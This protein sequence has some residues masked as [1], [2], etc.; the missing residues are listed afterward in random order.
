MKKFFL[1]LTCSLLFAVSGNAQLFKKGEN[2][3][4]EPK[5][6][7]GAV[8]VVNGKV[9]FEKTIEANELTADVMKA[10]VLEWA[11][12]RF[13]TPTVIKGEVGSDMDVVRIAVEEYMV[14]QNKFLVLD[15]TRIY[16]SLEITCAD[17]KCTLRMGNI[18]YW[19]E[20]ERDGG[21]RFTAEERITDEQAMNKKHTKFYRD[22]G[23]FRTK[24]IDLADELAAQIT[25][26]LAH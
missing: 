4:I 18:K 16:Y 17:G 10:K 11:A 1:L 23:K 7:A 12:T 9:L 5:Y 14:F 15:R 8:P 13:A 26:A 2:K 25:K 3:A 19:Y 20:E 22:Y 24:T 6:A 21:T